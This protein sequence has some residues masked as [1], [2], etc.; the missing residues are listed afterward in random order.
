MLE[1]YGSIRI[2][3]AGSAIIKKAVE[4]SRSAKPSYLSI[5]GWEIP[6][7]TVRYYQ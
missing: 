5:I 6:K 3:Y 7:G 2:V 1:T 4:K